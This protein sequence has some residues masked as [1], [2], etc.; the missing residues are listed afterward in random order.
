[1][2]WPELVEF[3]SDDDVDNWTVSF[4]DVI[5]IWMSIYLSMM[6]SQERTISIWYETI[7]YPSSAPAQQSKHTAMWWWCSDHPWFVSVCYDSDQVILPSLCSVVNGSTSRVVQ[8]ALVDLCLLHVH[9]AVGVMWCCVPDPSMNWCRRFIFGE[10][11]V[12]SDS[13]RFRY[14]V[15]CC[16]VLGLL[17]SLRKISMFTFWSCYG[18]VPAVCGILVGLWT[19]WEAIWRCWN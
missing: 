14:W 4:H 2:F 19:V 8:L 5:W 16:G 11:L 18:L 1:M 15:K 17:N 12:F 10:V 7:S 9:D 13:R 6:S 3:I